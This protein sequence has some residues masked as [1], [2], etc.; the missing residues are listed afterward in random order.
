[1]PDSLDKNG[2]MSAQIPSDVVRRRADIGDAL[3]SFER[4]LSNASGPGDSWRAHVANSLSLLGHLVKDQVAAYT[5][6]DGVFD[7]VLE[8]APRRAVHVE[9]MRAL[10]DTF[11]PRIDQLSAELIS[12][13]V[14]EIREDALK[15]LADILRARQKIADLVWDAYSVDL[16]GS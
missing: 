6:E 8:R 10:I 16:G 4:A 12:T 14:D 9:R 7:E 3:L 15:L 5:A 1:V 2:V 13:D 11:T